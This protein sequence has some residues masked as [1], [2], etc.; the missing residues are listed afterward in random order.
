MIDNQS[1][2]SKTKQSHQDVLFILSI[3]NASNV[4]FFFFSILLQTQCI[5]LIHM[6]QKQTE[7][8]WPKPCQYL[9]NLWELFVV[10]FKI[11]E[12]T[13]KWHTIN[14]EWFHKHVLNPENVTKH[15]LKTYSIARVNF[16]WRHITVLR[17]AAIN[18]CKKKNKKS[19]KM[20]PK[21]VPWPFGLN[22]VIVPF[23]AVR[24]NENTR[25]EWLN[26]S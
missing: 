12:C 1:G 13:L 10:L 18:I 11:P 24:T 4:F 19:E 26:V 7:L 2:K 17:S 25:S 9:V 14:V 8:T 23:G 3:A 21:N 5:C 22:R 6:L 20:T 15:E 16:P